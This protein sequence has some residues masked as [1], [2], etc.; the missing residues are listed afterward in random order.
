MRKI[1]VY[2]RIIKKR[3]EMFVQVQEIN[4]AQNLI[5]KKAF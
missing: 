2:K 3:I 4:L 1:S 5:T